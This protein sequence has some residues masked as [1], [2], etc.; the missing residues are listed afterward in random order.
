[1]DEFLKYI[2]ESIHSLE[3]KEKELIADECKD[4]A[5]LIKVR[6][7]VYGIARSFYEVVKKTCHGDNSAMEFENRVRKPSEAWKVS[8][9]KAKE[10]NDIEKAVIEEI[11]LQT[12]EDIINWFK[13]LKRTV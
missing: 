13:E 10:H 4:E 3:M 5:N 8:Y 7:N 9:D 2:D 12:L 6:I 11:K 1:M